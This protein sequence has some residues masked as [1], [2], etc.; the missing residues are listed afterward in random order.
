MVHVSSG[1]ISPFV[2][3]ETARHFIESNAGLP[4]ALI[5]AGVD[6][7]T[8]EQRH[9]VR[10]TEEYFPR[11]S[12]QSVVS[13][14]PHSWESATGRQQQRSSVESEHPT[15]SLDPWPLAASDH[16]SK[17]SPAD[18]WLDGSDSRLGTICEQSGRVCDTICGFWL[19]T[20]LK[21]LTGT[22]NSRPR[23]GIRIPQCEARAIACNLL[24]TRPRGEN[25]TLRSAQLLDK[26]R[27]LALSHAKLELIATSVSLCRELAVWRG[28]KTNSGFFLSAVS[29]SRG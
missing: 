11:G 7:A 13:G 21:V 12:C 23:L 27:P 17:C 20:C 3:R 1:I 26:T 5:P 16:S 25:F 29:I 4:D 18:S 14:V 22:S 24:I 6:E 15:R 10:A 9:D 2:R 19:D 28:F 8:S